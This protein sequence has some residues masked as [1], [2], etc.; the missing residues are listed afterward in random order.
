MRTFA[1]QE[2]EQAGKMGVVSRD[3]NVPRFAAQPIAHPRGRVLRLEIARRRELCEWIARAPERVCRLLRAK[4]AAVPHDRGPDA[5]RGGLGREAVN[6]VA[7]PGRQRT[8]RIDVG[9]DRIAVVDEDEA[10]GRYVTQMEERTGSRNSSRRAVPALALSIL[11]L[12][13]QP[14]ALAT[15]MSGLVDELSVR[16]AGLGLVLLVRLLSAGLGIAAGL[17][18]FQVRPGAV[19]LTK[20]S[21]VVSAAVDVLVYATPWAPHNRPPGDGAVILAASLLYYAAWFAY[22]LRSSRVRA[23]YS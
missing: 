20:A 2:R 1:Q 15:T 21:L 16:G 14:L 23:I 4:L 13:W 9:P 17:A 22:L 7:P 10:H 5:E 18:L 3:Q 6:G 8:S 19:S 12:I 11:L